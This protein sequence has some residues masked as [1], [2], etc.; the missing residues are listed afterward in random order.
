M[1][2]SVCWVI[3]LSYFF[4]VFTQVLGS[5]CVT[6]LPHAPSHTHTQRWVSATQCWAV[7]AKPVKT[8]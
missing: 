5:F 7:C 6:Q 4:I 8:A 2:C 1:L 3:L